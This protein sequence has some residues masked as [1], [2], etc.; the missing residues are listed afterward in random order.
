MAPRKNPIAPTTACASYPCEGTARI[1]AS[2]D[3]DHGDAPAPG[4]R[5]AL[6][7]H[8]VDMRTRRMETPVNL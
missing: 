8:R 3:A 5:H 1:I 4:V 7:A 6:P 2:H